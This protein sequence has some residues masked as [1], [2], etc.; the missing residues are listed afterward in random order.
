MKAFLRKFTGIRIGKRTAGGPEEECEAEVYCTF[1][2]GGQALPC[3][4]TIKRSAGD[5]LNEAS[6][7]VSRV[8]GLP[9]GA[10]YD[11]P[12]FTIKAS[13]YFIEQL[14]KRVD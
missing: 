11:H 5:T 3:K 14:A 9:P 7:E 13:R 10:Q 8:E 2:S 12:E 1:E 4:A 6:T